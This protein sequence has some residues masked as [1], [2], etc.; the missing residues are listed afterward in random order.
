[1]RKRTGKMW[2]VGVLA[3]LLTVLLLPGGSMKTEAATQNIW[4]CG[5][6]VTSENLSGNGWSYEPETNTLTLNNFN[7][8]NEQI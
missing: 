4:V 8:I 7:T 5:E 2:I 6:Q 1:M 3:C